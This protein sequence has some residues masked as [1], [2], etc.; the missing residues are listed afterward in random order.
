MISCIEFRYHAKVK[1]K[2]YESSSKLVQESIEK[3]G[4]EDFNFSILSLHKDKKTMLATETY[5]ILKAFLEKNEK[6]LNKWI[7]IK[8]N[9]VI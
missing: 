6:L 1:W 4:K 2:T 5:L 8:I 3:Y 7:N 9:L